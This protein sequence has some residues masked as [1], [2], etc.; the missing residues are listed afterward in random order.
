MERAASAGMVLLQLAVRREGGGLPAVARTSRRTRSPPSRTIDLPLIRK[1]ASTGKPM[2]ISTGMAS[3]GEIDEAVRT[4]RE[5]GCSST[6]SS[7]SARAPTRRRLRTRTSDDPAHAHAV[8]LRSGAVGPHDGRGRRV[9]RGGRARRW[10]RSTSRS[11][12]P[13]AA[14][15][16]RSRSSQRSWRCSSTETERAWQA[17][18]ARY[19]TG[20]VEGGEE[21]AH[22]SQ[23]ALR[24]R[25]HARARSF[26]WANLRVVRP[27]KGL[28]PRFY[29]QLL[30]KRVV[31]DVRKGTPVGWEL[32]G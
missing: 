10:S 24:R 11:A 23:V 2:I 13:M 5:A 14:W 12:A 32:L 4:A 31:R 8:R 27:G 9:G 18:A 21:I 6:S 16:P 15:I 1:V 19:S 20:R 22:V 25:G 30:G 17:L 26:T 29:Q 28:H 3:I 7:S